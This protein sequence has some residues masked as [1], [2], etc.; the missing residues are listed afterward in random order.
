MSCPTESVSQK[1]IANMLTG[2]TK[3]SAAL[4]VTLSLWTGGQ[5]TLKEKGAPYMLHGFFLFLYLSLK[6]KYSK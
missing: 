6:K 1:V 5:Q 2:C 3:I 4:S